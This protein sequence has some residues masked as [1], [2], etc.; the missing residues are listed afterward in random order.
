MSRAVPTAALPLDPPTAPAA[1]EPTRP[2]LPTPLPSA[3]APLAPSGGLKIFEA[4]VQ[5]QVYPYEAWLRDQVD[6]ATNIHFKALDRAGYDASHPASHLESKTFHTV[7]LENEYLQLVF[8][9]DLGGRLF[10]ITYKPT[11]QT[12]LYNNRVLKPSPWGMPEQKGWLAAGGIEWAFPTREHGYE[13]NLPWA[14]RSQVTASGASIELS[15]S[16][17]VDRPR[18]RVRV[19]LPAHAAYF[20]VTPR[21]ENPSNGLKRLQFWSNAL[22]TLGAPGNIAPETEFVM[23]GDAVWVHSTGNAWIP[24]ESV[25]ADDARAPRAP[26]SF[27]NTAGHDLRWYAQWDNYLGVFAAEAPLAQN[28]VGAYNHAAELGVARVFPP[29]S[30]PGVKLFGW[31]PNFC[32][33]DAYTDDGSAY[34]ELWGGIARTFF[35]DD[36]V[37]LAPGETREWT[38]AWLPLARTGGLSAAVQDAALAVQPQADAVMLAAYSAV[39]R[40]VVLVARQGDHELERWQVTLQP[41]QPWHALLSGVSGPV[42]LEMLDP[43][44]GP[45]V[46]TK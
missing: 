7:V 1:D 4:S 42:Q 27:S 3:P 25:P 28:F 9:P 46:K 35:P 26:I 34:F 45:I 8:I 18:V 20:T 38:E 13:W 43:N 14:Y 10:Q 12:L 2:A 32:C 44:A 21:I 29:A 22:L 36:D 41:A 19:T 16:A 31:G 30:A 15:D 24:K 37:T 33:R 17:A 5:F 39:A 23:P 11:G 6:P 40:P